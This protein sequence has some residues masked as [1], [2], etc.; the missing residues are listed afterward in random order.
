MLMDFHLHTLVSDGEL[1][2]VSLLERAHHHRISHLAITDHDSLGAYGWHDGAVFTEAARLGLQLTPGIEI[3][4]DWGGV[5]VHLLGFGLALG[6]PSLNSHL[7]R[8]RQARFERARREIEV[9]NQ[10]L[11][12]GS[13]TEQD[14]FAPGRETL[15]KPHFIHP[16]LRRNRFASYEQANAW[17]RQNVKTDVRVPKPAL[18]E[19]IE[20]VHGAGGW[21]ALAHPAYYER[22]GKPI[23]GRLPELRELGLDGVELDYPYHACSPHQFTR[24]AEAAFIGELRREALGLGLRASRGSDCHTAQ[25]FA[26]VYG[27]A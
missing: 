13:V 12:A 4:A 9:V 24:E 16:L 7:G 5:E 26:K 21:T 25:D 11:G 15:M 14:V 19:A 8:V 10:L 23:R 18:G 6:A 27:S 2:P 3:D 1:D 17:Y 20:L 22:D